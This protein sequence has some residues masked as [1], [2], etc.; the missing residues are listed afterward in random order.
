MTSSLLSYHPVGQEHIT[1]KAEK[2]YHANEL[3]KSRGYSHMQYKDDYR[4]QNEQQGNTV[5]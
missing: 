2:A 4:L 5:S 3:A 1:V